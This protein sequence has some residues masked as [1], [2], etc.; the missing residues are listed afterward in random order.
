MKQILIFFIACTML[1][2]AE[3]SESDSLR[4][5]LEAITRKLETMERE[6]LEKKRAA[7]EAELRERKALEP[8]KDTIV[9]VDTIIVD[10]GEEYEKSRTEQL[11]LEL[12]RKI[13]KSGNKGFGGSGGP[14]VGLGVFSLKPVKDLIK[15]DLTRRKEGSPF[16]GLGFENSIDGTYENFLMTGGIGFGG[17][18]N[19]VRIGGA[20]YGGNRTYKS[21]PVSAQDTIKE[22]EISIGYGGVIL[23]K[24]WTQERST[25]AVGTLLGAG[26]L[27]INMRPIETLDVDAEDL[28][29]TI[30]TNSTSFF[31]GELH[32]AFT[33]SL[34]SWFHIGLE[35]YTMLMATGNGF[36][37]GEGFATFNGGSRLRILFGNLG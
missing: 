36:E 3:L 18:G 9:V 31:A 23:E 28:Y 11:L 7:L 30:Y 2:G 13:A 10:K 24:A 19:G 1:V 25:F 21:N 5:E 15:S 29:N 26:G 6:K 37:Y 33:V 34:T 20:G 14:S 8:Q 12:N 22:M 16:H 32:C 35:G 4:Q 27:S 17:L